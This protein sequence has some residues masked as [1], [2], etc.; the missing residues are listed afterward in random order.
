MVLPTLFGTWSYGLIYSICTWNL[1]IRING[2]FYSMYI[3]IYIYIQ[4]IS[5]FGAKYESKINNR[6][7]STQ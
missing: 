7:I 1:E 3:W 5:G 2:Y 4:Y 6:L